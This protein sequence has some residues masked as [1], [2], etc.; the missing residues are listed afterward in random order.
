VIDS[1][2][3]LLTRKVNKRALC[4]EKEGADANIDGGADCDRD[5]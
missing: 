5:K 3:L 4:K 2:I 1:V